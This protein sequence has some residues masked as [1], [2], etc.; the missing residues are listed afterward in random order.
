V[1][2]DNVDN[3]VGVLYGIYDGNNGKDSAI[4]DLTSIASGTPKIEKQLPG[5]SVST[6]YITKKGPQLKANGNVNLYIDNRVMTLEDLYT[7]PAEQF[8]YANNKRTIFTGNSLSPWAGPEVDGKPDMPYRRLDGTT[9]LHSGPEVTGDFFEVYQEFDDSVDPY[10]W[11]LPKLH[12]FMRLKPLAGVTP[13]ARG[14]WYGT[15]VNGN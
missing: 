1:G 13:G 9:P 8:S 3:G 15:Q 4:L 6:L 14:L 5:R 10:Y 2:F 11:G 12:D 7:D